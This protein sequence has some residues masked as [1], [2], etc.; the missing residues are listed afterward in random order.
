VRGWFQEG[1]RAYLAG[2]ESGLTMAT[3]AVTMWDWVG[4]WW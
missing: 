3:A 1:A 2:V 4:W